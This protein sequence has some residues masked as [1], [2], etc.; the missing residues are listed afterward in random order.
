MKPW[1]FTTINSTDGAAGVPDGAPGRWKRG[2][3]EC[4]SSIG[5]CCCVLW[6]QPCTIGQLQ[7]IARGGAPW[8]CLLVTLGIIGLN[9]G[10][11]V[12][13]TLGQVAQLQWTM[14]DTNMHT[15]WYWI[16]GMLS[17]VA[18]LVACLAVWNA[19]A[20]YRKRD[21][22]PGECGM[23]SDCLSA[24][25]CAPCSVCQMF[26]QD[27]VTFAGSKGVPYKLFWSPYGDGV[28]ESTAMAV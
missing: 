8:A 7:S 20:K 24:W 13:Q 9:I 1:T 6:C 16:G 21:Q 10:G 3:F 22:I 17:F 26:S 5:M 11:S 2:L 27:D 14:G 19:R 18:S 4:F 28:E 25:C 12:F 15:T 23:F